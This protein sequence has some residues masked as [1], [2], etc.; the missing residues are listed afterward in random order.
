MSS[1]FFPRIFF[2]ESP[3]SC[4]RSTIKAPALR[5]WHTVDIKRYF[6]CR[7]RP[8]LGLYTWNKPL[9]APLSQQEALQCVQE[10]NSAQLLFVFVRNGLESTLERSTIAR[11]HMGLL[12][13]QL[14]KTGILPTAQYYK[15]S[16]S[17]PHGS[18]RPLKSVYICVCVC[19]RVWQSVYRNIAHFSHLPCSFVL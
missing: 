17:M 19:Q 16:A 7:E 18:G 5:Q 6:S 10:M 2:L 8:R 11:Q 13:H 12:L 4:G 1:L 9:C 15:G 3:I 14:V